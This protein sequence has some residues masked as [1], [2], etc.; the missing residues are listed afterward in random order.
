MKPKLCLL[1]LLCGTL[2]AAPA[3][4]TTYGPVTLSPGAPLTSEGYV[5]GSPVLTLYAPGV[6][7]DAFGKL[8]DSF[9][10][11]VTFG[12]S[13]APGWTITGITLTDFTDYGALSNDPAQWA[14]EYAQQITFC[15]VNSSCVTASTNGNQGGYG[16]PPISLNN[17][18]APAVT[19]LWQ[20]AGYAH[21]A[22]VQTKPLDSQ[23][24]LILSQ[25]PTAP[26][27]EPSTLL[28]LSAGAL[29]LLGSV[30]RRLRFA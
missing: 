12:F 22:Q 1:S 19:A 16:L 10:Q 9:Q 26:V 15:P 24:N 8:D 4:A 11:N 6:S 23:I 7:L 20:A 28:L 5:P 18:G 21:N 2:F 17:S 27:P 29:G 25:T 30:R 14:Y 13:L 3:S